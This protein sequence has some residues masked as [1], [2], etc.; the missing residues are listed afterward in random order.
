VRA[1]ILQEKVSGATADRAQ[2]KRLMTTAAGQ[3]VEIVSEVDLRSR[4]TTDLLVIAC[5][6]QKASVGVRSLAAPVFDTKSDY[7]ELILAIL[8]VAAKLGRDRIKERTKLGRKPKFALHQSAHL[9][10]AL[11]PPMKRYRRSS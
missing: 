1:R 5:G 8:S 6:L 9:S 7:T 10:N 4:D 3:N 11:R 2:L